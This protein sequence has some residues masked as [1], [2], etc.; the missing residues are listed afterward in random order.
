MKA[1]VAVLVAV[2]LA[3]CGRSDRSQ[4]CRASAIQTGPPPEWTAPAFADSS[5]SIR[6]PYAVADNGSAAA[7]YFARPLRAGHPRDQANKVLWVMKLPRDGHPL[8][9]TARFGGNPSLVMRIAR[10][11]DS[12]P[13]EIYP[14]YVDLPRAGCWRLALAWG[15]HRATLGVS[16]AR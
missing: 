5:P 2:L 4:R 7:F 14:S 16:V 12:G 3:G 13:G 15:G 8:E 11:A 6:I 1:V 10:P 9:I